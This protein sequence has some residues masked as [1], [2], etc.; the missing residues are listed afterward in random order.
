LEH[1]AVWLTYNPDLLSA[2]EV[3]LLQFMA[4]EQPYTIMSPYPGLRSAVVLTGWGI[5]FETDS[6]ADPRILE[7]LLTYQQ[8][9]QTPELGAPCQSGIGL[10]LAPESLG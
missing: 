5:Q 6:A 2:E 1:G 4:I 3:S 8:G 9:E 7:F 10:P